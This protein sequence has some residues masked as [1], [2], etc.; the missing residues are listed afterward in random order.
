[1]SRFYGDLEGQART[2][3]TRRGSAGSGISA[4]PRGWDVGVKVV[5]Y[6]DDEADTFA[7]GLTGGSHG[8]RARV[9]L[10]QVTQAAGGFV[11]VSLAELLGGSVFYI[12]RDGE[13][14]SRTH[15][16]DDRCSLCT[17]AISAT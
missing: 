15:D 14:H 13:R 3:A 7:V 9:H 5:G 6:D 4:H 17:P 12:D 1:M 8:N 10:V 2:A 16:D 11:R